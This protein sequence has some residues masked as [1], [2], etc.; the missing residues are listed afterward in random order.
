VIDSREASSQLAAQSGLTLIG[1]LL[2]RAPSEEVFNGSGHLIT[3]HSGLGSP[4]SRW[5]AA[6]IPDAPLAVWSEPR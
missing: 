5:V 6:A 2:G 3:S 1:W 4:G